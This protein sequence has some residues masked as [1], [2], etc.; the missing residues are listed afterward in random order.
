MQKTTRIAFD[1]MLE[2]FRYSPHRLNIYL[3][4]EPFL[5]PSLLWPPLYYDSLSIMTSLLYITPT[6]LRPLSIKTP[7]CVRTTLK[8]T[9]SSRSIS[10]LLKPL[11][12]TVQLPIKPSLANSIS[13]YLKT[14]ILERKHLA[15]LETSAPRDNQYQIQYIDQPERCMC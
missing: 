14:S 7:L 2:G 5:A 12:I 4:L 1:I 3:I 13:K 9:Q 10:S 6:L 8:T 15:I 11:Y